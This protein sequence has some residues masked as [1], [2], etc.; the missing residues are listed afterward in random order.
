MTLEA[1]DELETEVETIKPQADDVR[2]D[3]MRAIEEEKSKAAGE[4]PEP[5]PKRGRP[6]KEA[7][8]EEIVTDAPVEPEK[9][10]I[11]PPVGAPAVIKE[12]WAVLPDEVRAEIARRED[13]IHKKFTQHDEERKL[14]KDLKEVI[15][16][17]MP[18]IAAQGGSPTTA[19]ANL[20]N[21]AYQLNTG[22]PQQKLQLFQQLAQQYGID[23]TALNQQQDYQD[24][25]ILQL[26][27]KI[28]ELEQRTQPQ[29]LQKQLQDQME[30]ARITSEVQAFASDPANPHYAKVAPVMSALVT[31]GR[32][33]TLK[34]A[35]DAACW[36]DPEVRSILEAEKMKQL[37]EKRKQELEAK[38]KAAVSVSGSF[39][40]KATS[41]ASS[42]KSLRESLAEAFA[43]HN[44]TI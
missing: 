1:H 19:V 32:A 6:K 26:Q 42:S 9:P 4:E 34:E 41:T 44:S 25:Y 37:E 30:T 17:Y 10:M 15:S 20:L 16:P 23:I 22:T 12:K 28:S 43:Q 21:T 13:E 2:G 40:Q 31:S 24:P 27:N 33:K 38:K 8:A 18:L 11:E 35:Y 36:A 3:I 7:V 39:G 29:F 5:A 14:G